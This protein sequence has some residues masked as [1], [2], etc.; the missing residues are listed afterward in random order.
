MDL[1]RQ[2]SEAP[3]SES[4]FYANE[5]CSGEP[6]VASPAE[7]PTPGQAGQGTVP[8]HREP[9]AV[10]EERTGDQ[11]SDASSEM[12]LSSDGSP[13]P[14]HLLSPL[15]E[16]LPAV[17]STAAKRS[18]ED[19]VETTNTAVQPSVSIKRRK[20]S[21][22][23]LS[24]VL[25]TPS[26]L[27]HGVLPVELWQQVFMLLHPFDLAKCS[28]VDRIFHRIL[29]TTEAAPLP[30]GNKKNAPRIRVFD[31]D[32]VW[33]QA[34]RRYYPALPKPLPG[35][36]ELQMFKLISSRTCE[37]CGKKATDSAPATSHLDCGPG[38]NGVRPIWA[39][40]RALCGVCLR[41][42]SLTVGKVLSLSGRLEA[43]TRAGH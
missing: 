21:A 19:S 30:A 4:D 34:R 31:S 16:P 18:H 13:S 11:D 8:D 42:L 20:L 38:P 28:Q 14:E 32:T 24:A 2:S 37:S 33:A 35:H 43:D 39:L 10:L 6:R 17:A 22:K 15:P 3:S 7:D 27:L 29:T 23:T 9:A 25:A 36:T 1:S 40:A 41:N 12:D 26:P 5:A